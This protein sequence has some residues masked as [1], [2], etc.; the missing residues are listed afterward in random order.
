MRDA[1][2]LATRM[3]F[4][5]TRRIL[6]GRGHESAAIR[7]VHIARFSAHTFTRPRARLFAIRAGRGVVLPTL[8]MGGIAHH[9]PTKRS[10]KPPF[11]GHFRR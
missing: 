2:P 5:G 7:F 8:R 6:P 3:G 1:R 9:D 4:F 10:P 11:F